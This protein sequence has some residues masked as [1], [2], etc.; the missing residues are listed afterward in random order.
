MSMDRL[1]PY[2]LFPDFYRKHG[3]GDGKTPGDWPGVRTPAGEQAFKEWRDDRMAAIRDNLWPEWIDGQGWYGAAA[4]KAYAMTEHEIAAMTVEFSKSDILERIPGHS[5]FHYTQK[6]HF[7]Y[8]DLRI[9]GSIKED[10]ESTGVQP[11]IGHNF[12]F[13]DDTPRDPAE[14]ARIIEI[15]SESYTKKT[16]QFYFWFKDRLMR[17]RPLQAA[18]IVG[19]REFTSRRAFSGMHSSIVSGHASTGILIRC[20]VLER[21]LDDGDVPEGLLKSFSQYIVDVGDRRVFAGVH[22]PTDNISSWVLALELIPN[23]FPKHHVK[24]GQIV[25]NA[26]QE[27]SAV[28][29]VIDRVYRKDSALAHTVD[30][31][32]H[33]LKAQ[34]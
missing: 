7:E 18:L 8:E 23:V 19:Q 13:Y 9:I 1:P 31:L 22:Y 6:D 27:H 32:D 5:S 3:E 25:R 12:F 29:E 17:P 33:Y 21:W 2:G 15:L 30:F 24:I 28:Y 4:S 20:G 16:N 14:Q 34:V 11:K 10:L 26:I